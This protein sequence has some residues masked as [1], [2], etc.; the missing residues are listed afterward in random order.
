[1]AYKVA[2]HVHTSDILL[3][4]TKTLQL[5]GYFLGN[6]HGSNAAGR[7]KEYGAWEKK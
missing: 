7:L 5:P 1:M 3:P 4:V 6:H 2:P